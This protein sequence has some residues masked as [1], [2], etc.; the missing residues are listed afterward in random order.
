M[1]TIIFLNEDNFCVA[2]A[3]V[4]QTLELVDENMRIAS[5]CMEG[6]C[7]FSIGKRGNVGNTI[8]EHNK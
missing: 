2:C 8:K 6:P 7:I 3:L 1:T 4:A 5:L